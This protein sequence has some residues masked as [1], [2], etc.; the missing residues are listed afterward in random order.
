MTVLNKLDVS[1]FRVNDSNSIPDSY[2]IEDETYG[3]TYVKT[4][5]VEGTSGLPIYSNGTYSIAVNVNHDVA[6]FLSSDVELAKAGIDQNFLNNSAID[7]STGGSAGLSKSGSLPLTNVNVQSQYYDLT[8]VMDFSNDGYGLYQYLLGLENK[9]NIG[10]P[11]IDD[12]GNET[13]VVND[14]YDHAGSNDDFANGGYQFLCNDNEPVFQVEETYRYQEN[15][16]FG[17]PIVKT[18]TLHTVL[19]K[20]KTIA[21]AGKVYTTYASEPED[22]QNNFIYY[23]YNYNFRSELDLIIEYDGENFTPSFTWVY[24]KLQDSKLSPKV[25]Y[26]QID[27]DA[28]ISNAEDFPLG[29]RISQMGPNNEQGW[30]LALGYCEGGRQLYIDGIISSIMISPMPNA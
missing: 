6:L 12:M 9:G 27:Y 7:K 25:D 13:T 5:D 19:R 18:T 24:R 4:E 2:T 26:E 17:P 10:G 22:E 23:S 16:Q 14:N 11:M 8:G 1:D 20:W 30:K 28:K 29:E 3:G 15:Q 21:T